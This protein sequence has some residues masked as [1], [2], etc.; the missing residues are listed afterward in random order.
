MDSNN[1]WWNE[2]VFLH[3]CYTWDLLACLHI[4][5]TGEKILCSEIFFS[6]VRSRDRF[7]ERPSFPGDSFANIRFM[8]NHLNQVDESMMLWRGRFLFRQ[9]IKNKCHKVL[10]VVDVWWPHSSCVEKQWTV[11]WGWSTRMIKTFG[12]TAAVVLHL[13]H[14]FLD[15]GYHVFTD[16]YYNSVPLTHYLTIRLTYITGTLRKYKIDNPKSVVKRLKKV[17]WCGNRMRRFQFVNGRTNAMF[18]P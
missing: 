8:I 15:K 10:R 4:N 11:L 1:G 9:Y 2:K 14:E 7:G 13:M 17:K 3:S 18:L 12:Q 5:T 16:N 6:S